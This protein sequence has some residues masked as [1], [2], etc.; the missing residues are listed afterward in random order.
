MTLV[1]MRALLVAAQ[2]ASPP[3]RDMASPRSQEKRSRPSA[4]EPVAAEFS[5]K[6]SAAQ[7][8]AAA[9]KWSQQQNCGSCH[10]NYPYLMACPLPRDFPSPRSGRGSRLLREPGRSLG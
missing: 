6:R 5:P 4:D 8:D 2:T 7:I 1:L 10:T 3:A 9:L